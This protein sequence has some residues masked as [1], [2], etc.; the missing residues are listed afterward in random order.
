[1]QPIQSP[2][3][4]TFSRLIARAT[5]SLLLCSPFIGQEVCSNI[6]DSVEPKR[7]QVLKVQIL[8]DLSLANVASG[9]ID[10]AALVS[11]ADAF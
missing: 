7:R 5:E 3:F 10:V 1:M 8:T 11:L 4:D 9:L 2:W 6:I